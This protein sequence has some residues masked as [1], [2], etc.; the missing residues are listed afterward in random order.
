M[1]KRIEVWVSSQPA[2]VATGF[3]VP[4]FGHYCT[5]RDT[6]FDL[7]MVDPAERGS[8]RTTLDVAESRGQE[9]DVY[10]LSSWGERRRWRKRGIR[11]TPTVHVDGREVAP[12]TREGLERALE[13]A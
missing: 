13:A 8:L 10:Y 9:V 11:R 12:V 1:R 7:T 2:F 6:G 5:A 3:E 4:H